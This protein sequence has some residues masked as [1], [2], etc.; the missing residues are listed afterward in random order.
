MALSGKY[1]F[2]GIK[3]LGGAGLRAALA[4]SPYTAWL[5][6]FG[7]LL[8]LGLE[9]VANWLANRGLI[10]MNVGAFYVGGKVDQKALDN[11]IENG[12]K[13]VEN[14]NLKLTHEE[15]KAIDDAVIS[16]ADKALPYSRK[17]KP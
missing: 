16:A 14:P 10:I 12:L 15:M 11:A 7:S 8:D 1:N 6:K 3:K 4:S 5:L 2:E 9:F 17:P 13:L